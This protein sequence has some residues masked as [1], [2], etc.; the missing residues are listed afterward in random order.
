MYVC[1]VKGSL[2][3]LLCLSLIGHHLVS[4]IIVAD[5]ELRKAEITAMFCVNKAAPE[6]KCNGKCHLKK[7]LEE[8]SQDL[9]SPMTETNAPVIWAITA[10]VATAPSIAPEVG[11]ELFGSRYTERS[12]SRHPLGV[13][14]PPQV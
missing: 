13:F 14:H 11:D 7:Q 3:I 2:A 5:Y 12:S 6:M 8:E 4:S 1:R 9:P 10:S